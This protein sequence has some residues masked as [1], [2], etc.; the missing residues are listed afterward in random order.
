MD[1]A[2]RPH[3]LVEW[4]FG[5]QGDAATGGLCDCGGMRKGVVAAAAAAGGIVTYGLAVSG[6]LTL[7]TGIGRRVRPLGPLTMPMAAGR[8]VVFDVVAAPYLGR[9]PRA[10]QGEIEVWERGADMVVAAHRTPVAGGLVTTTVESVRFERPH[11]VSFRL[12]RGPVPLVTETF[13]LDDDGTGATRLVYSGEL[14]TDF[15]AAGGLWGAL[16]ARTWVATV[17]ASLEK[18]QAEAERRAGITR[19]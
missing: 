10:L 14:G 18:I 13:R 19:Q 1:G 8:E 11:V 17:A 16:V 9:T 12:L 4:V 6:S 15:W 5:G 3:G 7:D 2:V